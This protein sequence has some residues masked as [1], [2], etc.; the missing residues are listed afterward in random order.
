MYVRSPVFKTHVGKYVEIK[1]LKHIL[2][3]NGF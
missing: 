1:K 2:E 3:K